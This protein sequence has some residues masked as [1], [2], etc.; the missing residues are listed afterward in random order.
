MK[1]SFQLATFFTIIAL[2]LFFYSCQGN[3]K[4]NKEEKSIEQ[5]APAQ[6]YN[7]DNTPELEEFRKLNMDESHPNLLDPRNSKEQHDTVIS[8]WRG[9]HQQI[10]VF[11]ADNNF[12]WGTEDSTVQ[13]IHKIYFHPTGEIKTHVFK[14]MNPDISTQ[15]QEEFGQLLSAFSEKHSIAFSQDK[16][17]A[18]CGKTRYVNF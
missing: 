9:I 16:P 3:V 8:S 18:Q 12:D 17:F 14:V 2:S 13:I 5:I 4:Q 7:V 11:L 10:G 15:K 6:V 1:T